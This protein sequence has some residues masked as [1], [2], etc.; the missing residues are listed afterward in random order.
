VLKHTTL[1]VR[2]EVGSW[3]EGCVIK[4]RRY[5]WKNT[6]QRNLC[7]LDRTKRHRK[8]KKTQVSV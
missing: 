3:H 2:E 4:K 7:L 5:Q 6:G 1:N 8:E